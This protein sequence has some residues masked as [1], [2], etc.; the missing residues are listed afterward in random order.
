M[1]E[2]VSVGDT[3]HHYGLGGRGAHLVIP[4]ILGSAIAAILVANRLFWRYHLVHT[5]GVDDICSFFSLVCG[6]VCLGRESAQGTF[7]SFHCSDSASST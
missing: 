5:L 3:G 4:S 6:D 7:D 1:A 2:K